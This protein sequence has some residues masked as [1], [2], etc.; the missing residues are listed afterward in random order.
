MAKPTNFLPQPDSFVRR[1]SR[2]QAETQQQAARQTLC[3]QI[4][5]LLAH[6]KATRPDST[7]ANTAEGESVKHDPG[8]LGL[9]NDVNLHRQGPLRY[10]HV[11]SAPQSYPGI[12][13][14]FPC[15]SVPRPSNPKI[16]PLEK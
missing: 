5:S 16:H 9:L 8:I 13:S 12:G 6:P 10:V 11:D 2:R 14:S 15:S 4:L 1:S 7:P 3:W